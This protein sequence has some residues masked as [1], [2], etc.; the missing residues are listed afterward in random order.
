MLVAGD[1]NGD[2]AMLTAFPGMDAGLVFDTRPDPDSPLGKLIAAVRA[3]TAD[4][5]YLV[6]G[7]DETA[8]GLRRSDESV[9]APST[10]F[11]WKNENKQGDEK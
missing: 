3:G 11:E 9:L 4:R 5:R 7:R 8:G 1:A 10:A 6:Q 2:Y